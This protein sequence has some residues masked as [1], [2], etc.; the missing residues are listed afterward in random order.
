MLF[1]NH[2]S[3]RKLAKKIGADP[4]GK[5]IEDTLN[6]IA[7]KFGATPVHHKGTAPVIDRITEVVDLDIMHN[8]GTLEVTPTT[9]DQT[10][11]PEKPVDGYSQVSVSAVTAGIDENITASNI[12]KDVTILGVTGTYDP[13]TTFSSTP[14]AFSLVTNIENLDVTIPTGCT[15]IA[16]QAFYNSV[17]LKSVTIPSTVTS[18]GTHA[19]DGCTGLTEVEI[20]GS[21]ASIPDY[22]FNACSNLETVTLN[23]GTTSIGMVAFDHCTAL[24]S[25]DLPDTLTTINRFA[26][27]ACTDLTEVEIPASVTTIDATAFNQCTN[28]TTIVV[29][30]AEDS[31]TGA[32]WGATN[33]TV[34]WTGE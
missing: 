18:I 13:K 7:V 26:F 17:G 19:F 16:N 21:V 9:S 25:I 29:N 14:A 12:K 6:N 4:G 20:P 27:Q 3:I 15:S 10:I 32:P 30:K 1:S 8:L 11:V 28:I 5:T 22:A 33:A 31:I 23:H 24:E 2:D 34:T